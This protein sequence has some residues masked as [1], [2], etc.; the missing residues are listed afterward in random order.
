MV[1][2][3]LEAMYSIDSPSRYEDISMRIRSK[4]ALNAFYRN[5]YLQYQNCLRNT[6]ES[7]LI[8]ELGSGAG[9]VKDLIPGILCSD[10]IA[11]PKLDYVLDGTRLPFADHSV[12]MIAMLNVFH[13]IPDVE[14]FINEAQRCLLDGG[15]I[16]IIDPNVGWISTPILKYGHSEPFNP[17]AA[18]WDF[19]S[20]GPLSSAND[21]LSWIVFQRDLVEFQRKF[22]LLKLVRFEPHSPLLYW[23][24][25][26][27]KKWSLIGKTTYPIINIIDG[28]LMNLSSN[29]GSFVNVEILKLKVI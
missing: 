2:K 16:M 24:S 29:F 3:H 15:R 17:N 18:R 1:K 22:P 27:L 19:N 13:H 21:A 8:L 20:I 28:F 10:L 14:G 23:L 25:G 26:G 12:R 11:Y 5:A 7:G 6:P 4:F 9:F